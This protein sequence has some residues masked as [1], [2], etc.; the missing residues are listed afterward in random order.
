LSREEKEK[1]KRGKRDQCQIKVPAGP[2]GQVQMKYGCVVWRYA[3]A[4]SHIMP[5]YSVM[6]AG[7]PACGNL[8]PT[9]IIS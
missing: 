6:L 8:G 9:G 1:K 7:W 4:F 5:R 3:P 2:R